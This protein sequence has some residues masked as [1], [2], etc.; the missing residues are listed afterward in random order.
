MD[1][2]IKVIDMR[3]F[4]LI[5]TLDFHT[6]PLWSVDFHPEFENILISGSQDSTIKVYDVYQKIVLKTI[7]D[8]SK[9]VNCVKF[10]PKGN[11]IYSCS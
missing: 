6:G 11:A 10:D 3:D 8:H 7:T 2:T 5:H 9:S 1:K 4:E